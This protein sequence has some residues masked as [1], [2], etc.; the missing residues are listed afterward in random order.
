MR[1][2]T[3]MLVLLAG[4]AGAAPP[5]QT[6]TDPIAAEAIRHIDQG[7]PALS[8]PMLESVL[9]RLPG[10]PDLIT[11]LALALRLEGRHAEAA[12]RYDQALAIDAAYLPALAYQGVLFLQ[13]G[14]RGRAEAN[15]NRLIALCR[16]GCPERED[17]ARAMARAGE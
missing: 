3:I 7:R 5:P 6:T 4:A 11:Y 15:M 8:V 1:A 14:Q 16:D 2:W 10:N 13:T 17:L 12:A 9:A